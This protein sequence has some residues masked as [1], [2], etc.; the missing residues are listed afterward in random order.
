MQRRREQPPHARYRSS[1]ARTRL[2]QAAGARVGNSPP[3]GHDGRSNRRPAQGLRFSRRSASPADQRRTLADDLPVHSRPA[4]AGR[5]SA[6]QAS[7]CRVTPTPANAPAVSRHKRR[8][9]LLEQAVSGSTSS[10]SL[11]LP[12]APVGMAQPP[13][14]VRIL[15]PPP[16]RYNQ[17]SVATFVPLVPDTLSRAAAGRPGA[18]TPCTSRCTMLPC[19]SP[20]RR[21]AWSFRSRVYRS[22][23]SSASCRHVRRCACRRRSPA[24]AGQDNSRRRR[25]MSLKISSRTL[26]VA[27]ARATRSSGSVKSTCPRQPR[28]ASS[29]RRSGATRPHG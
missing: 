12:S 18:S 15:L 25:S 6:A 17:H 10:A 14:P 7:A 23:L 19:R 27:E 9:L 5:W 21:C 22:T 3:E 13:S 20:R 4:S 28:T 2:G 26:S 8:C 24:P 1:R 11:L 29:A 16:S